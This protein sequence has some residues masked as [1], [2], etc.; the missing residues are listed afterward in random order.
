M[1]SIYLAGAG[2]VV[3]ALVCGFAVVAGDRPARLV[4]LL[5]AVA[6]IAATALQNYGDVQHLQYRMAAADVVV[7]IALGA[8]A[9]TYRRT[10]LM[11][12]TAFQLLTV[13]TY[14]AFLLDK[15]IGA[16]AFYTAYYVWS[17]G[18][19][20]S[21]AAGAWRAIAKRAKARRTGGRAGLA[22]ARA[23]SGSPQAAEITTLPKWAP[24]AW[25]R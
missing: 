16:F 1:L 6:W 9:F 10:W 22:R 11:W 5:I 18:L 8:A 2:Y 13:A 3:M 7:L 24:E 19:L 15:R 12:A 23:L 25:W 21:L 20:A 17:Y 14:S 4:G